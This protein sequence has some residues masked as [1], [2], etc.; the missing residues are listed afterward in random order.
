MKRLQ[1]ISKAYEYNKD[2]HTAYMHSARAD[3]LD[4]QWYQSPQWRRLSS[5]IHVIDLYTCRI[6][7]HVQLPNETMVT[8]H[9]IPRRTAPE[10]AMTASNLWLLDRTCHN[11]KTAIERKR[12]PEQLKIM[13]RD[14]W[15]RLLE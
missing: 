5:Q 6:C 8:D 11:K 15:I 3:E 13:T 14:E 4:V 12:T 9:I 1:S 10:L 2:R 7:G